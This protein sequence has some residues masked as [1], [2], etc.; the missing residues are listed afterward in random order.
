MAA[1]A[2]KVDKS[3]NQDDPMPVHPT[4]NPTMKPTMIII[5]INMDV[6]LPLPGSV[7]LSA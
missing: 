7:S 4:R 2:G 6:L 5:P 1:Q 3:R